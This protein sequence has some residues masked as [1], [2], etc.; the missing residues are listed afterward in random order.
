MN[1]LLPVPTGCG[2]TA[3]Q[4]GWCSPKPR[5]ELQSRA[6]T[7]H[8][9]SWVF[10]WEN[11]CRDEQKNHAAVSVPGHSV[12][13]LSQAEEAVQHGA[14]FITHLFNAML[15]VSCQGHLSC[16]SIAFTAFSL[17]P[18][19]RLFASSTCFVPG[20]AVEFHHRTSGFMLLLPDL[21]E[22]KL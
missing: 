15:P 6:L 14:T 17:A 9:Y 10:L 16:A 21:R 12:A 19:K 20:L 4:Q 18:H 7:E 11:K 3:Q 5:V 13:N 1:P 22:S 8:L 2:Q